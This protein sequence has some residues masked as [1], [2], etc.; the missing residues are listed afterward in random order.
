MLDETV[1]LLACRIQDISDKWP[2]AGPFPLIAKF[3]Q[4]RRR[5]NRRKPVVDSSIPWLIAHFLLARAH[6]ADATGRRVVSMLTGLI[7]PSTLS[8]NEPVKPVQCSQ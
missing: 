3:R 1:A 2:H 7:G 4:S 6:R 8:G 5:W